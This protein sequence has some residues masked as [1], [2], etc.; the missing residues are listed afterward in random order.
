MKD[1]IKA[2]FDEFKHDRFAQGMLVGGAIGIGSMVVAGRLIGVNFDH[3]GLYIPDG[4]INYMRETGEFVTARKNGA[5]IF[6]TLAP[7]A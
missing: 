5:E 2:R 6:L 1:K 3:K 4:F 7:E